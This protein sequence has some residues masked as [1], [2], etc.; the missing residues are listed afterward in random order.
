LDKFFTILQVE[1][2]KQLNLVELLLE[3]GH[4]VDNLNTARS[5]LS[6]DGTQTTAWVVSGYTGTPS[7]THEQYN[8]SA[9]TEVA[10]LNTARYSGSGMGTQ[11]AA[12]VHNRTTRSTSS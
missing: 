9:W 1:L 10:D 2:L 11:S 3:L 8:G 4:L 7:A 6:G 5:G 12:I